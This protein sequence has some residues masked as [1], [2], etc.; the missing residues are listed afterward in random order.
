MSV[1]SHLQRYGDASGVETRFGSE[2]YYHYN[3]YKETTTSLEATS[4]IHLGKVLGLCQR[5]VGEDSETERSSM[6]EEYSSFH[7][8]QTR[9]CCISYNKKLKP[10]TEC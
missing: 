10:L 4:T 3:Y 1:V 6:K 8:F 2:I 5:T 7:E 9:L